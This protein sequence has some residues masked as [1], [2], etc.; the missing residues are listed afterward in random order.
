MW[1]A[2]KKNARGT[3]GEHKG[4][5]SSISRKKR[6]SSVSNTSAAELDS[7]PNFNVCL[8][9]YYLKIEIEGCVCMSM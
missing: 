9:L 1:P 2:K 8:D 7:W 6:E 3:G 5:E 4:S